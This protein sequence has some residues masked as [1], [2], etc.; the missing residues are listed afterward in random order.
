M[1]TLKIGIYCTALVALFSLNS[2]SPYGSILRS[3]DYDEKKIYAKTFYEDGNYEKAITL[4]EQIY[5]RSPKTQEGEEAYYRIGMCYF[6]LSDYS[7]GNYFLSNFVARFP[8]SPLAEDAMYHSVVSASKMSPNFALDQTDTEIALNE[9]QK[10]LD[11]YP[12]SK[13]TE[14]CN[15]LMNSLYGKIEK[16]TFESVKLYSKM[17]RYKAACSSADNFLSKYPIS[18]NREEAYYILV[19]NSYQLAINSVDEKKKERIDKAIER[20]L[21]FVAEFPNTTYSKEVKGYYSKLTKIVESI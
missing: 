9:I 2:C 5:Q 20:Y 14:E 15:K 4:Y 12:D 18:L 8:Y 10:F 16:K 13:Y 3:D 6:Y 17:E 11:V 1:R 21:N 7:M 19:K